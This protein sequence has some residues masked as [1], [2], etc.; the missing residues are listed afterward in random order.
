MPDNSK[1]NTAIRN[2]HRAHIRSNQPPCHLCGGDIDYTLPHDD[3]G[4]FVVDHIIPI[5]KGGPDVLDN[6][7]AAHRLC[8]SRKYDKLTTE[9]T[10]PAAPAAPRTYVTWRTW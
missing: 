1:R 3:P 7:A 8:N 5:A 2:R 10:K 4:S 9:L 6:K